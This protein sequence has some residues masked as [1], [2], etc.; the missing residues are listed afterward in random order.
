MK[1]AN[2]DTVISMDAEFGQMA[3]QVGQHAWGLPALS[4][5]EKAFV[6]LAADLC[7][8]YVG[9]PLRT[10]IA[11]ALAQG[12]SLG[13]Q[14]EAVRHLA[15]YVGYPAAA[16]ASMVLAEIE[17]DRNAANGDGADHDREAD[18]P[19]AQSSPAPETTFNSP[20]ASAQIEGL[21]PDFAQFFA[22]QFLGRWNRPGL[23]ARERALCTI[24]TDVCNGT[25]EDSFRL[26]L[27]LAREHGAGEEQVR[28]V[29][30]LVAEF[31]IA[32]TWRAY[33]V[34]HRLQEETSGSP[35]PTPHPP[36]G[37]AG[38]TPTGTSPWPWRPTRSA[39]TAPS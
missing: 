2:Q 19:P 24:A 12:V 14:R 17:A 33:I 23:S 3:L 4:M 16:E 32:K 37:C 34:L 22:E 21:D 28:A 9:F 1:L 8:H 15:P 39:T 25:L 6:F 5:R 20:P 35:P 31:G 30:L 26:H 18:D 38:T 10:H 29:L 36:D 11:M 7:A 27:E 13:A